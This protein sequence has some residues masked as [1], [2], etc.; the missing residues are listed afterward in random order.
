MEIN[1]QTHA[2]NKSKQTTVS[3]RYTCTHCEI[4]K[5][6]VFK[7]NHLDLSENELKDTIQNAIDRQ[8]TKVSNI[9][10]PN[11]PHNL[12]ITTTL[13]DTFTTGDA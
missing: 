3:G 11:P 8:T 10:Y 4:D 9:S 12:Q 2:I 1:Q 7:I 5:S 13:N 6:W